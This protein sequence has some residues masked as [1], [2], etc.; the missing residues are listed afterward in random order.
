MR[1]GNRDLD[2]AVFII[3]EIGANHEGN[4]D[5]AVRLIRAAKEAGA[6]AVKFQTYR[7]DRIVAWTETQRF[8][9]FRRLEL[10]D[11]EFRRLAAIAEQED[12]IFLSTPFDLQSADLLDSLV[13]AFKIASGDLTYHPLL[14]HV[15]SKGKPVLLS[16]GMADEEEIESALRVI[17]NEGNR[18]VVLLHCV[19]SY[20]TPPEEANLR[21]IKSLAE[22]FGRPSG[23]SDHTLGILACVAS[24]ALGAR[25]IEKHFTL[26]KTRATFRDH[27][28]SADP[29]DLK[30]LVT[31]VR[32][33]EK[34]LGNGALAPG[35]TEEGNV[36]SMRRS[37]AALVNIPAGTV[38]DRGMLTFLRP[39][40]GIATEK[41]DRII[42]IRARRDIPQGSLLS[43]DDI[44]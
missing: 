32:E 19:S 15:A 21:A 29:D 12:I 18:E 41:I 28:L 25:V 1:I 43:W 22:R 3:A 37:I 5:D 20:P 33:V 23:Y 14:R 27:Q 40:T 38:L 44:E 34:I 4:F 8:Q 39:G 24:A 13:P 17:E 31:Q 9:H 26:D 11:D 35:K 42:G 16:T 6:D 7:A 2:T 30:A 36:S 10:T